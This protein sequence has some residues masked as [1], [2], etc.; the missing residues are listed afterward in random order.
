MAGAAPAPRAPDGD[1]S[2]DAEVGPCRHRRPARGIRYVAIFNIGFF[3]L[4][5]LPALI[6]FIATAPEKV[7]DTP[8]ALHLQLPWWATGA[9][10]FTV[11]SLALNGF[12][13]AGHGACASCV[14]MAGPW[15]R[16]SCAC[17]PPRATWLGGLWR[18]GDRGAG[19]G[20]DPAGFGVAGG[21]IGPACSAG[22]DDPLDADGPRSPGRKVLDC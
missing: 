6:S 19:P 10:F 9:F 8:L 22:G 5:A 16:R 4:T 11:V 18:V 20:G 12:V 17:S 1:R 14:A 15:P 3:C 21:C 2:A 13:A 7:M